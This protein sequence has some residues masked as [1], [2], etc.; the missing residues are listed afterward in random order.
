[1]CNAGACTSGEQVACRRLKNA[2]DLLAFAL[3]MLLT[4]MTA[5]AP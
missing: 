3:S 5:I 2:R 1:M 4:S